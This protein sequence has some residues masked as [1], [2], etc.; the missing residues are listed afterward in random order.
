MNR[1]IVLIAIGL[2]VLAGTAHAATPVPPPE[3]VASIHNFAI[4][5]W[6]ERDPDDPTDTTP[7]PPETAS[8]ADIQ[9]WLQSGALKP[10]DIS[11]AGEPDW[12]IDAEKL[13]SAGYWCGTGGCVVQIWSPDGHGHYAKVYDRNVRMFRFKSIP[14]KAYKWMEVDYH[15][16]VCNGYGAQDCPWGHEWRDDGSGHAGLDYSLRFARKDVWRAAEPPEAS[17]PLSNGMAVPTEV[18][19]LLAA[20]NEACKSRGTSF[21]EEGYVSRVPD[22]NGDGVEDWSYNGIYA[23]CEPIDG[24][25]ADAASEDD[26][27]QV[28]CGYRLWLSERQSGGSLAWRDAGLDGKQLYAYHFRDG[29]PTELYSINNPDDDA[30]DIYSLAGCRVSLISLSPKP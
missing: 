22:L 14:G 26:C 25:A 17:D 18:T 13:P 1:P 16:S 7:L 15:G 21:V 20:Q 30:C 29:L 23:H 24:Q 6:P 12:L 5:S 3:V 28:D 19:A 2:T 4:A 11:P 10:I 9:G 27:A 8:D